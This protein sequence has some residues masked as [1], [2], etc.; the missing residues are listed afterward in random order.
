MSKLILKSATVL[1]LLGL[2]P[3]SSVLAESS[4][5]KSL[6]DR[7]EVAEIREELTRNKDA[8]AALKKI[9]D[10][11][12]REPENAE[13]H[14]LCGTVLQYLGYESLA[15]EH[16][17]IVDKLDPTR[18]SSALAQFKT[19]LAL[20]GPTAAYEYLRYVERRFPNDPSVLLMEG[21]IERANGNPIEAEFY[22]RTALDLHPNTPGI[23]TALAALRIQQKRYRQAI[24]LADQDLK[25]KKDHPA[26]LF[27]KGQAL[28]SMGNVKASI[29]VLQKV[30]E[31][32]SLDRKEPADL[33]AQAYVQNGQFAEALLPTLIAMS[34]ISMN[35]KAI[36]DRYK[37]RLGYLLTGA[38]CTELFHS[39]QMALNDIRD[40]DRQAWLC[41]AVGDVLDRSGCLQEADATFLQGLRL[42]PVGRGFLRLAKIK[43]KR[44]DNKAA[45]LFY[46]QAA[47]MDKKDPEIVASNKRNKDSSNKHQGDIAWQ[48]K[49]WM[50]NL[51][52]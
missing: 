11:L 28:L 19:K 46:E 43:E 34:W 16:Y 22:Y 51:L 2:A 45:Y 3:Q 24:D 31:N 1:I 50:R 32:S 21:M 37:A 18:P 41:Y 30:F 39:L 7:N 38:K 35:D 6:Y 52:D 36:A 33:M 40:V 47:I 27:A 49:N 12:S 26:A 29:P 25:L 8:Q 20:K 9:E 5:A 17:A 14:M 48:L 42:R 13:A 10:L 44:G 4:S 15:D 23:A